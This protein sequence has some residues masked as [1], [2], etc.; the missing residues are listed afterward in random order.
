MKHL[1]LICVIVAAVSCDG[2][3]YVDELE[4]L[5]TSSTDRYQLKLLDDDDYM[6]R[7]QKQQRLNEILARQPAYI[8]V[9]RLC[10]QAMPSINKS[11]PLLQ[12]QYQARVQYEQARRASKAQYKQQR[13]DQLGYGSWAR[14]MNEIDNDM[15]ISEA[16][17]D[18][19]ENDVGMKEI[20]YLFTLTL[21]KLI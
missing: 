6:T 21:K 12:Q 1:L 16:E 8:Q 4:D 2:P 3:V 5:V 18:R 11:I 7:S 17:A 20:D 15:S 14:Q 19:R 10:L 13:A 9:S